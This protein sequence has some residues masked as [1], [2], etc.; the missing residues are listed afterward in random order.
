[1]M[2]TGSHL[3]NKLDLLNNKFKIDPL[4]LKVAVFGIHNKSSVIQY[5]QGLKLKY[6]NTWF[7][8]N[9]NTPNYLEERNKI[10]DFLKDSGSLL[11]DTEHVELRIKTKDVFKLLSAL[12]RTGKTVVYNV[13][14]QERNYKNIT[15]YYQDKWP[16]LNFSK[17]PSG[18]IQKNIVKKCRVVQRGIDEFALIPI[19]YP[20]IPKDLNGWSEN[21]EI[22][23]LFGI[24]SN[25][26]KSAFYASGLLGALDVL[27]WTLKDLFASGFNETEIF[28]PLKEEN[29]ITNNDFTL[30]HLK[31]MYPYL[32]LELLD[33]KLNDI[34]MKAKEEGK[35]RRHKIPNRNIFISKTTDNELI[36]DA[37]FLL[38]VIRS[39]LDNKIIE[40]ITNHERICHPLG[41]RTEDIFN[42]AKR[43]NIKNP[44]VISALFDIL[45]DEALLV[46]HIEEKEIEGKLYKVRTFE[47]DG[48]IVS[49]VIRRSNDIL[50]LY[51]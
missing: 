48:E 15:V 1:M 16:I 13:N 40:K 12:N 46:T 41:F 4:L 33:K 14:K 3:S 9:L 22:V 21:S 27:K 20:A 34:Y 42:L 8:K 18:I 43:I 24:V 5:H 7:Y 37:E 25:D 26:N 32:N 50:G 29:S 19:A 28:L 49:D 23:E 47:P 45:I 39:E 10:I 31:V 6:P 38:R 17:Y 51:Y 2:L 30:S 36:E 11:L 44:Q 35:K